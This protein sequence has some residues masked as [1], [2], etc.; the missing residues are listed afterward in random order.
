[1]MDKS[2]YAILRNTL[3]LSCSLGETFKTLSPTFTLAYTRTIKE[4]GKK[5]GV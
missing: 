1:M 4:M 5:H 2:N 3:G